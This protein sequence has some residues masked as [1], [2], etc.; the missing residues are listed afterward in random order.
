MKQVFKYES[1]QIIRRDE[2]NKIQ[3][4]KP[5]YT[6]DDDAIIQ[7]NELIQDMKS[8]ANKFPNIKF[9]SEINSIPENDF[10]IIKD[11]LAFSGQFT[12]H[13]SKCFY[14][15]TVNSVIIL[16]KAF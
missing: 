5:I 3:S 1:Q 2:E 8:V 15:P 6:K 7:V 11:D 16:H 9:Q 4:I 10:T 12:D 14:Q 13:G